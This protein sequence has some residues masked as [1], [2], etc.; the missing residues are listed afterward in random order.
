MKKS[1]KKLANKDREF[2]VKAIEYYLNNRPTFYGLI[3]PQELYLFN[4]FRTYLK[5]K[6]LDFGHG[7]GFFAKFLVT[8][9]QQKIAVGLDIENSRIRESMASGACEKILIYDGQN[10]PIKNNYF[11]SVISNCVLEHLNDLAGSLEEI[12]RVLKPDGYFCTSVMTNNWEKYLF[13]KKI[14]GNLYL[15]YLARQQQ[16]VN[17]LTTK[18]WRDYFKKSNFKVEQEIAYLSPKNVQRLELFHYLSIFS[19]LSK[20]LTN[21]WVLKQST[22]FSKILTAFFYKII[23]ESLFGDVK[24]SAA[25][26][27]VLKKQ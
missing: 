10:I 12:N 1:L 4:Y 14:F 20:K 26:F 2:I 5:Q 16:H 27:Y 22:S 9:S 3:R 11:Q 25:I 24:N 8:E 6:I 23:Q 21:H 19:F 18:Q 13:G 7:D 15:R 17:L